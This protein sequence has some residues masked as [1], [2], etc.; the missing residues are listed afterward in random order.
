MPPQRTNLHHQLVAR[1]YSVKVTVLLSY[2]LALGFCG[3]GI[4]I[5]YMRVRYAIAFYLVIFGSI[6]VAAYKMGMVHEK[7]RVVSPKLLGDGDTMAP[8]PNVPTSSV[9]EIQSPSDS[10]EPQISAGTRQSG[11]D[12]K[13]E[14]EKVP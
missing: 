7:P 9:L 8:A 10:S 12:A 11:G 13:R 3:L 14:L 2:T 5:A 4:L 1:G 6:I